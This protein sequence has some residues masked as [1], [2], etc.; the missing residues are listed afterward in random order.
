MP[1]SHG[2][3]SPR[4]VVWSVA[5][6]WLHDRGDPIDTLLIWPRMMQKRVSPVPGSQPGPQAQLAGPSSLARVLEV[7]HWNLVRGE[8]PAADLWR[9]HG[10]FRCAKVNQLAEGSCPFVAGNP[11]QFRH[12]PSNIQA[13]LKLCVTPGH[14]ASQQSGYSGIDIDG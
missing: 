8:L 1:W 4:M 11:A 13:N 3:S 9:G 12:S 7:V 5:L 10:C 14:R 2:C 6:W